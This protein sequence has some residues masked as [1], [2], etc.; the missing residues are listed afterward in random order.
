MKLYLLFVFILFST[1]PAFSQN[2]KS[3]G[4]G[5]VTSAK[6]GAIDTMAIETAQEAAE[7]N[8]GILD[9]EVDPEKYIVGPGDEFQILV[10]LV[11]PISLK[12]KISPDGR[13]SIPSVGIVDLKNKN[14]SESYLLI[15]EKLK[16]SYKN[17]NSSVVLRDIRK[18]KV[19]VS[20][21][22]QKPMI[23]T[24]TP[25][26]RV[27]E[28]I[29]R[30]GGYKLEASI[31]NIKVIRT[32]LDT[33]INVDLEK[34]FITGNEE[35]NPYVLG[36][37]KVIV[38][39][40]NEV[41][42]LQISG[43]IPIESGEFEFSEGDSLSTLL[44]F[45][46][47]FLPSSN[48]DS[49]FFVRI[50]QKTGRYQTKL[51]DLNNWR[52]ILF[53][54][55][56]SLPG[57]FP[58]TQGDRVYIRKKTQWVD[59]E[60]IVIEGEVKYPGKYAIKT[61]VDKIADIIDR[62]GGFTEK[63]YPDASLY[64]RQAELEEEDYELERLRRLNPADMSK[65]ELRYFQVRDRERKGVMAFDLS[66]AVSNRDS[67]DNIYVVD[68]D[69]L[70]IPY[71]KDYIIVQGRVNNPGAVLYNPDYTYLDYIQLA[72]GFGSRAD[73]RETFITKSKGEQFV[74]KD[75]NYT[76]EPGDVIL[77]PPVQEVDAWVAFMQYLT[78][79]TQ[80]V[81]VVGVV[82]TVSR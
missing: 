78:V 42:P 52:G 19:T 36:A 1:Q 2:R 67:D 50:D 5:F 51:L 65:S 58:L 33:V 14:L 15:E 61:G 32:S 53:D 75:M 22:V 56:Q 68:K 46:H 30:A 64:I 62:A 40:V 71:K 37:D 54:Y 20:G 81:A 13:L 9:K 17:V 47:G 21:L 55:T 28:V 73:E 69:S 18:F 60:Y 29:D 70:I 35:T 24:A 49:V 66:K 44:R 82:A 3:D 59:N 48:L 11:D 31:R 8:L 4:F 6:T 23:V 38:Y 16:S 7:E 74:A 57:D 80:L 79:L 10:D 63:A 76:L 26:D 41:N 25:M 12:I 43:E 45:G 39:P 34:Y 77:V 27:S 72:G